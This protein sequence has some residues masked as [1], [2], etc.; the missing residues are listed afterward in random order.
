MTRIR[1]A[2]CAALTALVLLALPLPLSAHEGHGKGEVAPYDL[3]TPRSVSPETAAHIG[4]KTAE[5]DFGT[6][7]EVSRLVGVVR[8]FPD[9]VAALTTRSAGTVVTV[10]VQ[11]GDAVLKGQ[12]VA[13][14]DS[15]QLAQ[16]VYESNRLDSE[17][18]Q[19]LGEVARA[20]CR[21]SRT[22]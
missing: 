10:T 21:D 12:V 4:L 11:P 1:F 17:Y 15:P 14:V 3:D 20:E 2:A 18:Y 6:V 13:E 19:L 22:S 9:A 7:E 8:P 16:Y 5:V